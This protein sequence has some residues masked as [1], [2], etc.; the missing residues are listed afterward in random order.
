[1]D[2]NGQDKGG[3]RRVIEA[4]IINPDSSPSASG[5]PGYRVR[6]G[7]SSY[8]G[9]WQIPAFSRD[10]C[11]GPAITLG[12][13]FVCL[14]QYGVLAAIGFAVFYGICSVFGTVY[15]ARR[16]M[17]GQPLLNVWSLRCAGWLISFLVTV[18]LAGGFRD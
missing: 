12:I 5:D 4:E 6:Y 11:L 16:L 3:T 15:A 14:A 10:G 13:F 17:A 2:Q 8:S 1:M 7:S 18:W 9:A